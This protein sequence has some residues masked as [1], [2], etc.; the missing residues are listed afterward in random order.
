MD[1]RPQLVV[2]VINV[3]TEFFKV[4]QLGFR[5][6][7]HA[8]QI[9]AATAGHTSPPAGE[10]THTICDVEINLPPDHYLRIDL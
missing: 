9:I 8:D 2:E 6:I 3:I 7:P 4:S 10:V 1:S 5:S